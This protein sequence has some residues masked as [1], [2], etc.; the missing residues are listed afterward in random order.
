MHEDE[1]L[2]Y[3][4]STKFSYPRLRAKEAKERADVLHE[5]AIEGLEEASLAF[6][7]LVELELLGGF[8]SLLS[9]SRHGL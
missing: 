2:V 8:R 7:R 9:A 6:M 4:A 1:Y 3:Q 5:Q